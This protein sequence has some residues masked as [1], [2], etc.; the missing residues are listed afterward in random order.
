MGKRWKLSAPRP[1]AWPRHQSQRG[2]KPTQEGLHPGVVRRGPG[3]GGQ[4][5]GPLSDGGQQLRPPSS[6]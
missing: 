4:A 6:A 2:L 5:D 3:L 1:C